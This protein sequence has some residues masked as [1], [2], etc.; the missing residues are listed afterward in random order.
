MI[1]EM[2]P[3]M[4]VTPELTELPTD[5]TL[6]VTSPVKEA[7]LSNDLSCPAMS[8]RSELSTTISSS[9]FFSFCCF[10][11]FS[12][13]SFFL[14]F[15][16]S[17]LICLFSS[18]VSL[19][20]CASRERTSISSTSGTKTFSSLQV[21][22]GLLVVHDGLLVV[23]LL[24]VVLL[25]VVL[26]VVVLLVVVLLVVV[27]LVVVLLVVVLLVVVLLVVVLLVVVLLVVV[28]LVVHGLL[29]VVDLMVVVGLLVVHDQ[30]L[31]VVAGLRVV[32]CHGLLVVVGLLVV[33]DHGLS[34]VGGLLVVK[35]GRDP[36]PPPSTLSTISSTHCMNFSTLV[37][38]PGY[39]ALAHPS[40]KLTTPAR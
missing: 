23:G 33:H 37:Y 3:N 15:L 11:L 19:T 22:E 27:L 18:S 31:L 20:P 9:E 26:L 17:S 4:R 14:W 21:V 28:L 12:F 36:T 6:S 29:V 34:V 25:V 5:P 32:H 39:S 10:F 8:S 24:V 38:T 40:P 7:R 13:L 2:S 35:N 30:G 1:F 16:F